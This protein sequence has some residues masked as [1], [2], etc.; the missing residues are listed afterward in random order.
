MQQGGKK[1]FNKN[2]FN[3]HLIALRSFL[4]Y[5]R[6]RSIKTVPLEKIFLAKTP[7][8]KISALSSKEVESLLA[9]PFLSK[10]QDIIKKRD[11]A[12][13]ALLAHT[14][15]TV[16][17]LAGLKRNDVNKKQDSIVIQ[18]RENK[19]RSARLSVQAKNA[20]ASYLGARADSLSPLFIRHDRAFHPLS[21]TH[22]QASSI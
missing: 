7:P 9:A 16:S 1:R 21:S 4:K 19:Y 14:G 20:L 3:Y 2:T 13:L 11:T 8:R 18:G 17:E 6:K 10:E 22:R 5:A 12:I 15:I